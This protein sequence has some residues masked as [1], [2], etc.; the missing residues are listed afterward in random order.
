MRFYRAC[1]VVLAGFAIAFFA[2]EMALAVDGGTGVSGCDA[3][4]KCVGGV[5]ESPPLSGNYVCLQPRWNGCDFDESCSDCQSYTRI[6]QFDPTGPCP[7]GSTG[8]KCLN[9]EPVE[10]GAFD[11]CITCLTVGPGGWLTN[12]SCAPWA[13]G[14]AQDCETFYDTGDDTGECLCQ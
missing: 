13:C 2:C 8:C 3:Q 5:V 11:A 10:N 14:P 6:D 4:I 7:P 1:L 9:P 12:V